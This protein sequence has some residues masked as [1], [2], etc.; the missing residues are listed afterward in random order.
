M[1]LVKALGVVCMLLMCSQVC[2]QVNFGCG[3]V[4]GATEGGCFLFRASD[5]YLH[6]LDNYGAFVP[7][8]LVQVIG[9]EATISD[10]AAGLCPYCG[11]FQYPCILN[12]QISECQP[13]GPCCVGKL[14][15][16]NG[17]GGDVP[18]IGDISVM[19]DA[20]FITGQCIAGGPTSNIVCLAEADFNQSGGCNPTCADITIGDIASIID[21]LF[22]SQCLEV[23]WPNCLV[24]P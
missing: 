17:I 18:T 7:G 3:V 24:C 12:V 6:W 8:D 15:D 21:C 10:V 22:I 20:K 2:A 16:A 11:T 9:R 5:G 1:F 23:N 4:E 14:G 19:I 13:A